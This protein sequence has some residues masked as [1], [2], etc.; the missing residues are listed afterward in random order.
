MFKDSAGEHAK[1]FTM[2]L[3]QYIPGT[4]LSSKPAPTQYKGLEF[5]AEIYPK[6][7][8]EIFDVHE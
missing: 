3:N 5:L 7:A 2:D 8:R 4:E 6:N 1:T